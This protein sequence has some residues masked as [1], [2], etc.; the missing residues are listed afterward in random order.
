MAMQSVCEDRLH[1]LQVRTTG[2]FA[3]LKYET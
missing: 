3:K 1:K 2:S